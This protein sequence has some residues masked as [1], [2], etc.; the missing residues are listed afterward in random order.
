MPA[1]FEIVALAASAGGLKALTDVLAALPR[2]FPAALVVVQHLDPRHRSLMAE[3]LGK[4]TALLVRE[5]REGD[6]LEQGVAFARFLHA[7]RGAPAEDLGHQAAMARIEVLHHHQRR[8]EIRRQRGEHVGDRL[9][10]AGGR[11]ER[12]DFEGGRH[13]TIIRRKRKGQ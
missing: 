7:Q 6:A 8:G 3:I 2:D 10:A 4:R 9:Q 11:G 13:G 5:A 12:D 1:A